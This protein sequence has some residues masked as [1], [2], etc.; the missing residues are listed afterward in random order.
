MMTNYQ[1]CLQKKRFKDVIEKAEA[2]IGM[3]M[4]SVYATI[5]YRIDDYTSCIQALLNNTDLE[6]TALEEIS[7]RLQRFLREIVELRDRQE[8]YEKTCSI[9][10]KIQ[11]FPPGHVIPSNRKIIRDG[12][13]ITKL[14]KTSSKQPLHLFLFN[15]VCIFAT[16]KHLQF[17][18]SFSTEKMVYEPADEFLAEN[19]MAINIIPQNAPKLVVYVSQSEDK[20][21]WMSCFDQVTEPFRVFRVPIH[22]LLEREKRK[23]PSMFQE[24]IDFL[25][26]DQALSEEGLFRISA[27]RLKLLQVVLMYDTGQ[28][29]DLTNETDIHLVSS[30]LKYWLK[31]LPYPLLLGPDNQERYNEWVALATMEIEADDMQM[32]ILQILSSLPSEYFKLVKKLVRF[33]FKVSEEKNTRMTS[34]NLAIVFSPLLLHR[35]DD[36]FQTSVFRSAAILES[37]KSLLFFII[38]HSPSIFPRKSML[39]SAPTPVTPL[40]QGHHPHPLPHPLPHPHPPHH[41][42]HPLP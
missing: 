38:H 23:V 11:N 13:V 10:N 22:V 20:A 2:S 27:P 8:N 19:E 1:E 24:W 42:P 6:R 25:S 35:R 29:L 3:S 28:K 34:S 36:E 41:H 32:R 17:V 31:S 15:D 37:L 30:L 7:S 21:G 14:E 18:V 40:S 5:L 16:P 4:S 26:Q 12:V 39:S 9:Y 33:L